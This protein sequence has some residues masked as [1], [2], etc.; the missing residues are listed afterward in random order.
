MAHVTAR[1]IIQIYK[2]Q[3]KNVYQGFRQ[4]LNN[5]DDDIIFSVILSRRYI[6]GN[7][8]IKFENYYDYF[9]DPLTR[10]GFVS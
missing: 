4:I 2:I 7:Y 9:V 3:Q 1:I 8:T 5:S 10:N 6:V